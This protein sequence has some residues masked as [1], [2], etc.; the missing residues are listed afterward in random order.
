M[1]IN[2]NFH[3]L[4]IL[5]LNFILIILNQPLNIYIY[6]ILLFLFQIL[7][8]LMIPLTSLV[9]INESLTLLTQFIAV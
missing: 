2:L 3:H 1:N 5:I 6:Y 8:K 7:Q 9:D 4:I